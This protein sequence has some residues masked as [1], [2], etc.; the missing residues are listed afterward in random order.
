ML[1]ENVLTWAVSGREYRLD[2]S[3]PLIMGI[4]NVTPDSFSDG[5]LYYQPEAAI[6]QARQHISEGADVLDIGG[7]TTRPGSSAT[8]EEEEWR[9]IAPVLREAASWRDCPPIS[10]D[11]NKA[12]IA[13]KALDAG[14]SIINDIWAGRKEP[15]ILTLAAQRGA[16]VILM[17]ML[18]EPRT[19]QVEPYYD[20]V[21][22]E[23][24]AFLLERAEAAMAAGIA[25]EMIILDPGMGFGKNA[26]HNLTLLNHFEEVVPGG[27]RSLMA[28]SRKAFL[29][30]ITGEGD[31][32]KRDSATA[33]ANAIAVAKGAQMIRVHNV[34]ASRDAAM[35]AFAARRQELTS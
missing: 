21:V 8:S 6:K 35:V 5:G 13:E 27:F 10:V 2:F 14:A 28:L 23:V 11:T 22:A 3:R 4:I 1:S 15:E 25:K 20:D 18:G 30:R 31:P 17:H 26:V 33:A 7:E 24:R 19:M 16:P 9:R 12:A 34:A 32:L 29:G